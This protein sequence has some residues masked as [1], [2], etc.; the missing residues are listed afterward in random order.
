MLSLAALGTFAG[1]VAGGWLTDRMG[2]RDFAALTLLAQGLTVRP[3]FYWTPSVWVTA[4]LAGSFGVSSSA[5]RP[6]FMWMLTNLS[7]R[8]RGTMMGLTALRNQTGIIVGSAVG[9]LLLASWGYDAIGA[10]SAGSSFL[11]AI[12]VR[13]YLAEPK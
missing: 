9:G 3:L 12:V 13:L 4:L 2:K 8:S 6:V 11:G 10:F 1:A 5:N 7:E